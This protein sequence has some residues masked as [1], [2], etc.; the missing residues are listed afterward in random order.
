MG[1]IQFVEALERLRSAER[2]R[3]G[4]VRRPSR[5]STYRDGEPYQ[6][7]ERQM[8][9]DLVRVFGMERLAPA[10]EDG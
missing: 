4:S 1:V 10:V 2:S 8:L 5:T 9:D 6:V 3:L 7:A